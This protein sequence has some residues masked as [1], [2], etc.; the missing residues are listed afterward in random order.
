MQ[1][2]LFH[3]TSCSPQFLEH[4]GNEIHLDQLGPN[5]QR[6]LYHFSKD[7]D[8]LRQQKP[9]VSGKLIEIRWRIHTVEITEIFSRRKNISSNQLL[10]NFYS[11][12]V[13]FTKFL[14]RKSESKFR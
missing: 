6:Q 14:P 13:T 2:I 12:D 9:M 3:H 7:N 11:K 1:L 10:S 5:F 4:Q 8:H